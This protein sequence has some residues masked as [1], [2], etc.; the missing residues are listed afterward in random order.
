M[1]L[2]RHPFE[3]FFETSLKESITTA[4]NRIIDAALDLKSKGYPV[5]EIYDALKHFRGTLLDEREE[6]IAKEALEEIAQ[7]IE[8]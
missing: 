1:H 5:L 3:K 4:D 6:S 2:R 8:S 7:W